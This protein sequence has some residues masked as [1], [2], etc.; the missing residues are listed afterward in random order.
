MLTQQF[1]RS[2]ILARQ[3]GVNNLN[4]RRLF[5]PNSY[6]FL[7]I[8]TNNRR[9][10]LIQNISLLR[11][12]FK[13]TKK[14]YH[15]EIFAMVVLPDH[16]HVLVK[17]K[18]IH[19]YPKI[20][21][22]I[23]HYFSRKFNVVGQVCPTYDRNKGIWQRRYHEH[24]IRDEDDLYKHLD[25]IHYNPVKHGYIKSVKDWEYSSFEKFVK[26]GNYEL[27]WGSA[28]DIEKIKDLDYE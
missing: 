28:Q 14:N 16:F 6:V 9:K 5:I 13:N 24:T 1:S 20:I 8:I 27:N 10:I 25:Y 17:P 11:E 26:R 12:S 3:H 7:T 19:E 15:F 18:D 2:G 22:S 23:K 21:S 4:Y